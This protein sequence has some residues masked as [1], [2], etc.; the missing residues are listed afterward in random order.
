MEPIPLSDIAAS[1]KN[2]A[3]AASNITSPQVVRNF[4]KFCKVSNAGDKKA[5]PEDA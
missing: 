4:V 1:F 2:V 5:K 3:D